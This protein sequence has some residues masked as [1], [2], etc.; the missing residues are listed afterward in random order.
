MSAAH[1]PLRRPGPFTRPVTRIAGP[2][3]CAVDDVVVIATPGH[4]PC[5]RQGRVVS[6]AGALLK[7]RDHDG[8]NAPAFYAG[9]HAVLRNLSRN[10]P[11]EPRP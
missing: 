7:L 4:W 3:P 10:P 1:E 9:A 5:T 2:A 11:K 6:A 8:P